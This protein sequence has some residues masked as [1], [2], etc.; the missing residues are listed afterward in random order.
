MRLTSFKRE[1]L[2]IIA[3]FFSLFLIWVAVLSIG[4][5][6]THQTSELRTKIPR[7]RVEMANEAFLQTPY[8]VDSILDKI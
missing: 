1:F 5:T 2:Y 6:T 3:G 4:P 7:G 8:V